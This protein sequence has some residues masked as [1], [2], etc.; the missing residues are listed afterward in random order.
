MTP[1]IDTEPES[2]FPLLHAMLRAIPSN[3]DEL[4]LI[5]RSHAVGNQT[6]WVRM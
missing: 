5:P 3:P 1:L 2:F 6:T 4:T